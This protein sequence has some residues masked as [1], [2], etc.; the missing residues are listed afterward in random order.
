MKKI[1]LAAVAVGALSTGA[2]AA[3]LGGAR[4]PIAAVVVAPVFN[5]TGFYLG[6]QVGYGWGSA[7]Q[8]YGVP[9]T[10]TTF[11]LIQDAARQSGIVGGLHAGYLYQFNQFVIGLEGD[12]EASGINGNDRGSGGHI[13]G[14]KH[15]WNASVRARAGFAID[16][17]LVYAT[18][19]V[20]FLGAN[21]T[22]LSFVPA[23]SIGTSF[24]G[25]TLGA[26][27]EY[28]FTPNLSARIEYR[29]TD[30]GKS[31]ARFIGYAE[32]INPQIHTV[33]LGL[34]YHFTTGPSAV[35]ARY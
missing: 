27:V 22:N 1:L 33:R 2:F 17:A 32:R 29:Y 7:S 34:S 24:T 18:G 8:P 6:G 5:W 35:V 11:P 16:R 26:G 3:D 10:A 9:S 25:W 14:L 12:I 21:A 31:T 15:R 19:G 30:Y 13:N 20:A 4:G 23:E 28:A